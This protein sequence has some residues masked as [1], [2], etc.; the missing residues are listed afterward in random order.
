MIK[1]IG[2]TVYYLVALK[3]GITSGLHAFR[4]S[5]VNTLYKPFEMGLN[6]FLPFLHSLLHVFLR[7]LI[8]SLP[9]SGY[10]IPTS[11]RPAPEWG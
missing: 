4:A 8:T 7:T 3:P 1:A 2:N 9:S 11:F 5:A 10:P 6:L